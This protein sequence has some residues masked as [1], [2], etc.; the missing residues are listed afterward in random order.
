VKNKH[1]II[2]LI[3][4]LLVL[5]RARHKSA[6]IC[7]DCYQYLLEKPVLYINYLIFSKISSLG[8]DEGDI[9]QSIFK[10]ARH[11]YSA[12]ITIKKPLTLSF[13]K[14]RQAFIEC[15][16]K[17]PG[18]DIRFYQKAHRLDIYI[19]WY[20]I[21]YYLVF[22]GRITVPSNL[23]RP[24]IGIIIDD[25]GYDLEVVRQLITLKTPFTYS[26]LPW[27]PYS[28]KIAQILRDSGGEI[29]L[30]LP[31]EPLGYPKINPGPG[32]LLLVMSPL[33]LLNRLK[34]DLNAFPYI[35]GVNNHMGSRF[36]QDRAYMRLVL[37]EIKKRGLFFVDSLTAPNSWAYK[38]ALE[39][40]IPA[41][42]RDV[43]LDATSDVLSI[44]KRLDILKRK[45]AS[46]GFAVAICHPYFTTMMVLA[47]AIP[48]LKRDFNIV[49][50]SEII[51]QQNKN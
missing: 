22:D 8:I 20:N 24:C 29:M 51:K 35:E 1:K 2:C 49:P 42:R 40:G 13:S 21:K 47:K 10:R 34:A 50:V 48:E 15:L 32:A 30:H 16:G 33:T 14:I 45:A 41:C 36:T 3:L 38:T 11:C 4:F 26:I 28:K 18:L 7:S 37:E 27:G 6:Y 46:R 43:F 31:M 39:L 23:G 5:F 44:K 9:K 17:L 19:S 25:L 12:K